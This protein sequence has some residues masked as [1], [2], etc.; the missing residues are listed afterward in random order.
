MR[1]NGGRRSRRDGE[2]AGDVEAPS[3]DDEKVDVILR[4]SVEGDRL[5]DDGGELDPDD[6]LE[7]ASQATREGGGVSCQMAATVGTRGATEAL[8][9]E[10]GSTRAQ[11]AGGRG[12]QRYQ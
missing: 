7:E 6:V 5:G 2:R 9:S 10:V 3:E 8:V 12:G 4:D 1:K 11:V